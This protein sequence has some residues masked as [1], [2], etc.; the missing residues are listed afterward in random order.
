[1]HE[2]NQELGNGKKIP[3]ECM[4]Q[5]TKF[6]GETENTFENGL[7]QIFILTLILPYSP[8]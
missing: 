5:K 7:K 1:M 8:Q 3:Y 4:N 2:S 6:P